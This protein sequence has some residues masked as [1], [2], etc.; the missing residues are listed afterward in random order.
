MLRNRGH[1]AFLKKA[2]IRRFLR[3]AR[4]ATRAKFGLQAQT[5]RHPLRPRVLPKWHT[6]VDAP[7]NPLRFGVRLWPF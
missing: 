7:A 3:R 1:S 6:S 4:A 2:D 5:S